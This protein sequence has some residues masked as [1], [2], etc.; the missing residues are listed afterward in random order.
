MVV[1][2]TLIQVAQ[3]S[4]TSSTQ[5]ETEKTTD[6]SLV[7][8]RAASTRMHGS[9]TGTAKTEA[10]VSPLTLTTRIHLHLHTT[11]SRVALKPDPM[12]YPYGQAARL[13]GLT[14]PIL[15]LVTILTLRAI[16]SLNTDS[17]WSSTGA[18]IRHTKDIKLST[19]L[20]ATHSE[21]ECMTGRI[22]AHRNGSSPRHQSTTCD[23]ARI[24][25]DNYTTGCANTHSKCN[26]FETW[27]DS[28][29]LTEISYLHSSS[30]LTAAHTNNHAFLCGCNRTKT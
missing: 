26:I 19:R 1:F 23:E 22:R 12:A 30:S 9:E 15:C 6:T 10:M 28:Q 29:G 14:R 2:G 21:N 24:P 27:A 18:T 5:T 17:K 25:K 7:R 20:N 13:R 8:V 16:C 11:H 3:R 4:G